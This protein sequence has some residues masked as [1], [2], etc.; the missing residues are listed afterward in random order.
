MNWKRSEIE[1]QRKYYAETA[2]KYDELHVSEKD[3]HFFALS[4]LIGILDFFEIKSIL[5]VGSGTGRALMHIK[6]VVPDIHIIGVEPV[7]EL[8]EVGYRKGLHKTELIE[9]YITNLQFH[10]Q[11]FD[12]L[13]A[14]GVLH[15]VQCPSLA[16]SEMLRV[17]NKAI[18][19]SDSNNFGQGSPFLRAIKQLINFFG[20]WG[21]SNFIRT[22]GKGY[23]ISDG[24][25]LSYSYSVFN[26][27]S[28][29]KRHCASIHILNTTGSGINPYR[30][31]G[32]VALLA[33]KKQET[34]S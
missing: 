9:G 26:N 32:H 28:L 27:I 31:A 5:D 3:E 16:I 25:G 30:S 10:N 7:E 24:D 21:L 20:L 11:Q 6:K 12:L 22:N 23:T 19:I 13:C 33:I 18:F 15:H 4:F 34:G 1:I 8:R 29:L 17:A 14:F 2:E